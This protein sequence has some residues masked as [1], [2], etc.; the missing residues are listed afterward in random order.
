MSLVIFG[1]FMVRS[2]VA[3]CALVIDNNE[4]RHVLIGNESPRVLLLSLAMCI[5]C[6][7][8]CEGTGRVWSRWRRW[9]RR[10]TRTRHATLTRSSRSRALWPKCSPRRAWPSRSLN[11]SAG[12][13]LTYGPLH[14]LHS[15][16]LNSSCVLLPSLSNY[17]LQIHELITDTVLLCNLAYN[18]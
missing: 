5:L 4:V 17:V 6:A 9:R 8:V 10:T 18:E 16:H 14:P 13:L 11:F 7:C 12:A 3:L 2:P 1:C 15:A